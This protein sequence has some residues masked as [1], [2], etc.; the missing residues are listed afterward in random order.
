MSINHGLQLC[1][2]QSFRRNTILVTTAALLWTVVALGV[3]ADCA[4]GAALLSAGL[5]Q[6][7]SQVLNIS[8]PSTATDLQVVTAQCDPVKRTGVVR[9]SWEP[10]RSPG[11][12]QRMDMTMFRD[13]FQT[14]QFTT[15]GPLPPDQS[16]VEL[17]SG[18]SNINYAWRVLT[19]T[20]A[21]WVPSEPAYVMWPFCP[22][23]R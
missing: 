18:E 8:V 5:Q 17:T 4:D 16:E 6:N 9:L 15:L 21:G 3:W 13:G 12:Q 19:L 11:S 22:V 23:T 7:K 20:A 10:A 1:V 14:G 2:P